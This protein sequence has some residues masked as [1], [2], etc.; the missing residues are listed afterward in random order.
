[1]NT[2][3][4]AT[5]KDA[6]GLYLRHKGVGQIW[7]EH[8]F[9]P[10]RT[11]RADWYLPEQEPPVIVEYDG[12][13][14]GKAYGGNVGHASITGILRDS[15]K[16]NEATALGIRCFRANAKSIQDG[17]FFTLLDRVLEPVS[18]HS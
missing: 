14:G 2:P 16:L 7:E 5:S 15:E 11:W 18:S 8:L 3:T 4:R 1:V 12:L 9:H 6:L 13:V 10:T 17:S